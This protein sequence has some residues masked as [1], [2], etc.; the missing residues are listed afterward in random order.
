[1]ELAIEDAIA[2]DMRARSTGERGDPGPAFS[3]DKPY[4]IQMKG[5]ARV[6]G[7]LNG[8]AISGE[9]YGFFETYR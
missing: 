3:A 5:R 6:S 2:T 8:G 4:F 7:R 1:V 9:G